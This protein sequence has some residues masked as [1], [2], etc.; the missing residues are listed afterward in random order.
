MQ[1]L[2]LTDEKKN[3]ILN[4]FKDGHGYKEISKISNLSTSTVDR[5]LRSLKLN[6]KD[7]KKL[8]KCKL[9]LSSEIGKKYNNLTILSPQYKEKIHTWCVKCK[10]DCGEETIDIL[11]K[12]K[13]GEKRTCGKKTC[14]HHHELSIYNGS[15]GNR[16][17]GHGDI[18]GSEWSGWRL[19]AIR[20][21]IDF[22][23][24]IEDAWEIF[25]KQNRKCALTGELLKF[26]KGMNREQTASL[27][28]IDSTKNYTKDNIQWVHKDINIMKNKLNEQLF[29]DYC[30]K[31]VEWNNLFDKN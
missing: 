31:V 27:D 22:S 3:E 15:M 2:K 30:K 29:F 16:T 7:R 13:N 9:D 23:I 4:L 11:R 5:F 20:R 12:I 26:K 28:R 10:C 19:G 1:K 18:L 21:D 25:E 24:S 6:R 14:K 8:P 17:T